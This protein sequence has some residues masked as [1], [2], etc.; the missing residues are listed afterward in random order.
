MENVGGTPYIPTRAVEVENRRPISRST[1][2][3]LTDEEARHLRKDSRVAAVELHLSYGKS[4]IQLH[5]SQYS[6]L[7]DKSDSLVID[8]VKGVRRNWGLLRCY[9]GEQIPD[10]GRDTNPLATGT[11]QIDH[12]GKNVDVVVTSGLLDPTLS[13]FQKNDDGTGGSRVQ[14]INWPGFGTYDYTLTTAQQYNNNHAAAEASVLAGNSQG[15]ARDSDIYCI[16]VMIS[17]PAVVLDSIR[18]WHITK[19]INPET[20]RRNPTILNCS[21][22]QAENWVINL[23]AKI[24]FRGVEYTG[25][26]TKGQ[27]E[28]YGYRT[29]T[30]AFGDDIITTPVRNANIDF[31]LADCINAGIIV[32]GSAGNLG[33]KITENQND[34]DYTNA[35][36]WGSVE[37]ESWYPA[38]RSGS[39]IVN[40]NDGSYSEVILS[41]QYESTE[42]GGIR[43]AIPEQK[44][45]FS[46][47]GDRV[48]IFAP[49]SN[50]MASSNTAAGYTPG[51]PTVADP[52]GSGFFQKANGTSF[53]A[54]QVA[55]VLACL[56]ERYPD[57]DQGMANQW[58][59]YYCKYDQIVNPGP[60][61]I[62]NKSNL[63]G[64]PNLYLMYR[65]ESVPKLDVY[66]NPAWWV[67]PFTGITWPRTKPPTV[68]RI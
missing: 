52:R 5:Y 64:A 7:W 6:E 26:F 58:L 42:V 12:T 25:P 34:I 21:W 13:E 38:N 45:T 20:G 44:P 17:D 14:L 68:G 4:Y 67:R 2:Y 29:G 66:P 16:S 36:Y 28:Q 53:S 11:I 9:L 39:P 51:W 55:G 61:E 60:D 56:A 46:N 49:A 31:A 65:N 8:P 62:S 10:W 19:P 48:N 57:M 32:T 43:S 35:F 18:E 40:Y 37:E 59:N 47:C 41:E 30:N 23:I 63:Q 33:L 3:Y 24:R 22:G 54:P 50:I 15:W 27:L 1:H